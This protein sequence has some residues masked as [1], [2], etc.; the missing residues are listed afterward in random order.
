MRL[1]LDLLFLVPDETGGRETY[2]RELISAMFE[3]E[4]ALSA[5]AFVSREGA[6]ALERQLGTS[7]R[8]VR[9]PIF[10]HRPEQWAVGEL[11]LLPL[12]GARAH[13]DV[14]HSMANFAPASGP[15]C[16]VLTLHDLQ[17]RALPAL[18]PRAR[19]IG[20]EALL[21][22]SARRAHRIITV[23]A[24]S[25]DELMRELA[26]PAERI[27]LIRNGLG[28][29]SPQPAVPER[30]LRQRHRL[31]ARP[32]VLTVSSDLPHKNLGALLDALA[33]I[34]PSRRPLLVLVGGRTDRGALNARARSAGVAA[35]VRL[36]GFRPPEELE[37]FY[38]LAACVVVPS[39]YEGFGLP[40]LEAMA[41]G[42]PVAC[43]D[44]PPLREV[45]GEAAL[46]FSPMSTLGMAM[47]VERLI[48]DKELAHHLS[49]AGRERAARFSWA[50]AAESTLACYRRVLEPRSSY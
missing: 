29:Q 20:T 37:G 42:T 15:F 44:I 38:R 27:E 9:I 14:L 18:L 13:V 23:S 45:A 22:L 50:S 21:G 36:L 40:V 34:A 5:T 12:C 6:S 24:F 1:G 25:R 3:I 31:D 28:R 43:S 19:R 11:A 30:E 49:T 46:L 39:L 33:L 8:V 10:A 17:Y 2:A 35:D 26:I 47:A 16:R 48:Q 32:V 7:M 4:P 41:R